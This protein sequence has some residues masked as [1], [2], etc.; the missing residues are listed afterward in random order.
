MF[1]KVQDLEYEGRVCDYEIGGENDD[2]WEE[3]TPDRPIVR[4]RTQEGIPQE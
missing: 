4:Q 1:A 2:R 3:T